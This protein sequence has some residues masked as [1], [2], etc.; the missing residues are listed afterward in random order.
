MLS[1]VLG[2]KTR[3]KTL[4]LAHPLLLRATGLQDLVSGSRVGPERHTGFG[5]E[6][7][8]ARKDSVQLL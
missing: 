7:E 4:V 1:K 6:T 5:F 3:K 2:T 8:L